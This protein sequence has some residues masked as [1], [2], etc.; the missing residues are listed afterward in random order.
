MPAPLKTTL[1]A[2]ESETLQELRVADGVHHRVRD[3]AHM[4]LLNADGWSVAEIADIFKCHQHTVRASL[5]R[6]RTAGLYGLWEKGGRG[7]KPTWDESDLDYLEQCLTEE[8]RTYNSRQLAAKLAADRQVTLSPDR[9]RK[10][11]KKKKLS[12]E[13]H[14]AQSPAASRP[15]R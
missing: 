4:L 11:L 9:I 8:G 14:S 13:T 15:R 1:T 10:L 3:R 7:Q 2:A 5:K 6:W 12:M